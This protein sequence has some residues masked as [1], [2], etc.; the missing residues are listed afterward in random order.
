M[1][2]L[3]N[4]YEDMARE[5]SREHRKAKWFQVQLLLKRK[6][7]LLSLIILVLALTTA[8]FAP[9][10]APYPEQGQGIVNLEHRLSP[11]SSDYILGTDIYGRDLVSRVLY[12]ARIS[13]FGGICIV[14]FAALIGI[15]L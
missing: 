2:T 5:V 3:T 11:P 9:L 1:E 6:A 8:L 13:L 10:I 7:A 15:P 14:T 12:G 4:S